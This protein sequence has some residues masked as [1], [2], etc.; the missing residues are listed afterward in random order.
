M[1][2]KS[3]STG[4]RDHLYNKRND[5]ISRNGQ[6]HAPDKQG[7][8]NDSFFFKFNISLVI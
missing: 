3:L 8:I 4:S 5:S 7:Q 1:T 6:D 2:F